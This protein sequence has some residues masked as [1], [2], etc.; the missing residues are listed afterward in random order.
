M[1]S[2]PILGEFVS[3]TSSIWDL[4]EWKNESR[5]DNTSIITIVD[6]LP[7]NVEQYPNFKLEINTAELARIRA[8]CCSI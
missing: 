6:A 4:G 7:K 3:M 2:F 8:M 1:I 5:R